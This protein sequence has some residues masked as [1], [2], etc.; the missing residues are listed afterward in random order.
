MSVDF[1]LWMRF[2]MLFKGFLYRGRAFGRWL[3]HRNL[4]SSPNWSIYVFIAKCSIRSWELV[5]KGVSCGESLWRV[6]S[7]FPALSFSV[8]LL[9][10]MGWVAVFCHV[11]LPWFLPSTW[12]TMNWTH[13]SFE[14]K[15]DLSSFNWWESSSM[16]KWHQS[17]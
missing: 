8:C 4:Y 3:D 12:S 9:A 13:Q 6:L 16:S 15:E 2:E 7:S 11:L 17:D 1:T 5:R 14:Q 10:V